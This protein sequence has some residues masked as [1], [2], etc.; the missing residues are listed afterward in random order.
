MHFTCHH[1]VFVAN[2]GHK[3][4]LWIVKSE[5][6]L[7]FLDIV[8]VLGAWVKSSVSS[9]TSLARSAISTARTLW[10]VSLSFSRTP[11]LGLKTPGTRGPSSGSSGARWAPT[12]VILCCDLR[13]NVSLVISGC[14]NSRGGYMQQRYLHRH[15]W[16]QS[17][18]WFESIKPSPTGLCLDHVQD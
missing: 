9:F 6:Y 7:V 12:M 14:S 1:K 16:K 5:W 13:W 11:V 3:Q 18:K 2:W 10:S 8:T 4:Q 15:L 17:W